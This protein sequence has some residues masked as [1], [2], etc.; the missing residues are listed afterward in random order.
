MGVGH[1][2]SPVSEDATLDAFAEPETT[3]ESTGSDD[4]S[5]STEASAG[6]DGD[7]SPDAVDPVAVTSSWAAAAT[8]P[9]CG[10]EVPRL[11]RN[12]DA[13]VCASCKSWHT[14]GEEACDR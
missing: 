13:S 14:T 10:E 2:G 12:G 7:E 11:W 3:D 8:C 5:P 4:S 9:D 6:G 1:Q